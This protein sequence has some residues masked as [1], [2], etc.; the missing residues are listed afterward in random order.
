KWVGF[1][2]IV[3]ATIVLT[4]LTGTIAYLTAGSTLAP[5]HALSAGLTRMRQGQYEFPIRPSG[6]PEIRRSCEAANQLASTLDTL[7]RDNR[8]LLRKIVSL[9]DD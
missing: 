2:A 1:L 7:S 3:G 9:Q 5:L 8:G 4:L 6:P